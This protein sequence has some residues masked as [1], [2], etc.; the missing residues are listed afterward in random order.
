MTR[1]IDEFQ[2][3]TEKLWHENQ[4]WHY[5]ALY[6]FRDYR[7]KVDIRRNAYDFQSH[8]RVKIFDPE[9]LK[10][11]VLVSD[12]MTPDQETHKV[13]FDG[14]SADIRPFRR[15]TEKMLE[16]ARLVLDS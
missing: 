2:R 5:E 12:A 1:T 9:S 7:L 10:W 14:K 11:N 13:F 8:L 6:R 4:S 15:D 16:E 3:H